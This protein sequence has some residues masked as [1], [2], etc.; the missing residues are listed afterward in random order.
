MFV[1]EL[2]LSSRVKQLNSIMET[3]QPTIIVRPATPEDA[4]IIA[5]A[6]TMALGEET[7]RMYCG[8]NYQDVLEELARMEN[9]Q[10][11]YRNALVADV[12]GT[13]AGAIVGYDGARLHELRRPTL[14]CIEERTGQSFDGVED[15]TYPGEYYL[16]SLGVLPAYRRLGI[17][18][19][20]LSALRDKA[21]AEGHERAGLLVDFE[22]PKAEH[23]YHTLGFERVE[24][25]N[26]FGH[27]MWHLQARNRP[28]APGGDIYYKEVYLYARIPGFFAPWKKNEKYFYC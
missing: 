1:G 7:M 26:L 19:R 9:T 6:L 25:R 14:G 17:G 23:L 11:S 2:F 8:E 27:R 22:N 15:E 18:G 3:K 13:P 21:F 5:A 20:L 24:A 4:P 28:T 10:Y 16:D 12:D